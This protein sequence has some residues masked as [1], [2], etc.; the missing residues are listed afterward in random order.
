[1][2]LKLSFLINKKRYIATK[3]NYSKKNY[4]VIGVHLLKETN[5]NNFIFNFVLIYFIFKAH[6]NL[7]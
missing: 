4:N 6:V 3:Y 1:M 5:M 2:K 7:M